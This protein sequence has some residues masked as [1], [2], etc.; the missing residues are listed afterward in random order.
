MDAP[1]NFVLVSG[2]RS[3]EALAAGVAAYGGDFDRSLAAAGATYHRFL[4]QT[5][6]DSQ[7]SR[8]ASVS[9]LA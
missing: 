3:S 8:S 7:Q 5:R 6:F 4:G 2:W 1:G 9:E